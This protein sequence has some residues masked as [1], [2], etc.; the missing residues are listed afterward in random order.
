MAKTPR[1]WIV[2][3]HRPL[4]KLD[5]NLWALEADMPGNAPFSRRMAIVRLADGQL[6]FFNAIPMDDATLAEVR[7]WGTP[8]FVVIPHGFHRIDAHAFRE[9]LGVKLVTSAAARKRVEAIVPVDGDLDLVP[10]DAGLTIEEIAG[11]KGEALL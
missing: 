8:A 7:A 9:K 10:K 2:T 11:S 4:E 3:P 6:V 1:P 5:D